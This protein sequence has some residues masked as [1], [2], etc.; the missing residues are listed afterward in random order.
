MDWQPIAASAALALTGVV[1]VV[2]ALLTLPGVWIFLLGAILI[3]AFWQPDLL[4]WWPIGI[5]LGLAVLGELLEAVASAFGAKKFGSSPAGAW[6][7]VAGGILGA[8]IGTFLLPIPIVGTLVGAVGGAALGAYLAETQ[9]KKR[10]HAEAGKAAAGAAIGRAAATLIKVA[11]A[12]LVV[13]LVVVATWV[14]GF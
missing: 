9:Y 13:A 3:K 12:A 8:L 1:G 14:P 6:G 7:S 11:I 2:L 5:G 4:S 10:T